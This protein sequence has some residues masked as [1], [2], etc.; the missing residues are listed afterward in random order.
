MFSG[1]LAYRYRLFS[2][3]FSWYAV[4]HR[5]GRKCAEPITGLTSLT[6]PPTGPGYGVRDDL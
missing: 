1:M 6:S 5:S 3:D 2:Y 4:I